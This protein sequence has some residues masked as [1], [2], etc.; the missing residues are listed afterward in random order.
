MHI[1]FNAQGSAMS[2]LIK[3]VIQIKK[4][5]TY[6]LLKKVHYA[7]RIPSISYA[8]GLYKGSHLVGVVT[9]GS[10]PSPPL[11]M[12]ICGK[13]YKNNVSIG[14]KA[15]DKLTDR[16]INT[17]NGEIVS[18]KYQPPVIKRKTYKRK[19][20]KSPHKYSYRRDAQ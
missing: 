11:A 1:E 9:Y 19:Y 14:Y 5:E 2:K 4:S 15:G 10:P 13:Q 17:F 6:E 16:I 7:K 12:G 18:E 20:I 8:F 3:K